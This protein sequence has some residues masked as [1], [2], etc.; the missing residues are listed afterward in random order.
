MHDIGL[1]RCQQPPNLPRTLPVFPRVKPAVHL[2]Q[3]M[4]R[5]ASCHRPWLER[6]FRSQPWPRNEM[7]L[8]PV[9]PML[10]LDVVQRIFLRTADN[11]P[12][13]NVRDP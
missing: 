13:D 7:H 11:E 5:V 4:H 12:R 6:A 2:W 10:V 1:D 9:Q 3:E 8:I